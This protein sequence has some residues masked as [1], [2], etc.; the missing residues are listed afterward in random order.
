M[1]DHGNRAVAERLWNAIAF[2]DVGELRSVIAADAVWRMYGRSPLAG[3]YAGIDAILGFMAH[4]G[5]LADELESDLLEVFTSED[6]A[7]LR[8][9]V[10]AQR[11]EQLLDIE[12]LFM[13]R[14][15]E[16]HIVEGIF[17][18]VDQERYDRF[19]LGLSELRREEEEKGQVRDAP[20]TARL[21][22][23]ETPASV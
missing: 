6:G 12:H 4:T 8:Y 1:S 15:V 20:G 19:W 9:S 7:V 18:P 21:R 5:E 14:I 11:G 17:A 22:L 2:A 16:G 13:I 23:L 3:D 10:R